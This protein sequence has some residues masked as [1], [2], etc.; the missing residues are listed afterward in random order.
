MSA[1][2]RRGP[3]PSDQPARAFRGRRPGPDGRAFP[4]FPARRRP[5]RVA[6]AAARPAGL[7]RLALRQPVGL[8]RQSAPDL[9]R[10][11][12]RGRPA[13][14]RRAGRLALPGEAGGEGEFRPRRP[15][16]RSCCCAAL[17]CASAR[18]MAPLPPAALEDYRSAPE[19]AFW[20]AE[21]ALFAALKAEHRGKPFWEWRAELARRKPAS[22]RK[23]ELLLRE[24]VTYQV[25]LQFLFDRQWQRLRAAAP[26]PRHPPDGRPADL[27]GPRLG[28]GLG[29]SGALRPR[30]KRLAAPRR[31]GAARLLQQRRPALGQ[32]ALQLAA[33][34]A[35][36]LPLVAGAA[37]RQPAADRPG[38]ARPLPR[39]RRLLAG[40]AP[41]KRRP[42]TAAG[43][44]RPA[45]RS[46]PPSPASSAPT[47]RWSPRT[48]ARSP[49]TSTSCSHRLRPARHAGAA[50][51]L[52]RRGQRAQPAPPREEQRGLHRH[53]RQRHHRRLVPQARQGRPRAL[54]PRHRSRPRDAVPSPDPRRL[55]QHRRP[56][57]HADAGRARPGQR[58]PHE[59]PRQVPPATGPGGYPPRPCKSARRRPARGSPRPPGGCLSRCPSAQVAPGEGRKRS[60]TSW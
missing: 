60:G 37:A 17:S 58:R 43:N 7:G 21:W 54:P 26:R 41:A 34:G 14:A 2:P 27:R 8:R 40:G 57:P 23:A 38:A 16:S 51:R 4:R 33:D 13:V 28:R 9:A 19:Q 24:E 35:R 47:C 11:A 10:A 48:S 49:P 59:H 12:A 50:V 30:R 56:R 18:V 25:F 5:G 46:S 20:L 3:A 6:G 29:P 36:R 42:R 53:P 55:R 32:S 52:R 22:L 1:P 15:S 31:R 44:R 45:T 39:L